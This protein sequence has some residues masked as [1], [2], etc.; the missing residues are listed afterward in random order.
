MTNKEIYNLVKRSKTL[1]KKVPSV[2][3]L[4]AHAEQTNRG[5]L[6]PFAKVSDSEVFAIQRL[7]NKYKQ[8]VCDLSR[9]FNLSYNYTWRLAKRLSRDMGA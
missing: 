9:E 3:M 4:H 2:V 5:E 1:R 8:R 7:H 6:H